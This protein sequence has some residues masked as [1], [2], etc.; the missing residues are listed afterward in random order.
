[1]LRKLEKYDILEEIGHGG[2]A[3]VY[4][5]RDQRL[6]REVAVKVLHPHLRGADEARSRFEREARSVARL[7]H[8]N[9]LEIYDYS[10]A[11]SEES[12]IA[13]ELL[14][15]PTLKHFAEAHPDMPAEIAAC[16][17]IQIARALAAA[18]ARGIIHRDVKPENVLL[19]ENRCIKLTD[20]G[21]AQIVDAQSFTATGQ[22]LGSPGHMAP[23]QVEGRD[24]DARTDLFSLG[25]VLYYLAA[26]RLPFRGNNPHQI[27]KRIVDGEYPDPLRVRPAV[28]SELGR[29]IERCLARDPEARYQSADE[30]AEDLCSFVARAGIEDP[31]AELQAYLAD[32]DGH[33]ALL[34]P[35]L[36]ARLADRGEQAARA[37]DYRGA[38]ECFD[39]AL[40]LDE[41]NARVLAQVERL[42][43]RSGRR[44]RVALLSGVALGMVGIIGMAV[45][46]AGRSQHA[47]SPE[48]GG[49]EGAGAADLAAPDPDVDGVEA[50]A[51]QLEDD[52]P[53]SAGEGLE[54][55]TGSEEASE[56]QD[57][58]SQDTVAADRARAVTHS[59]NRA[60]RL[61][62][63]PP[64]TVVL[65]PTP[66]NVL[67]G[68]DG[69]EP[70]P[71][72]PSFHRM[73]LEPGRH[74]FVFKSGSECCRDAEFTRV[75]PPGPGT[76]VVAERLPLRPAGL[77]VV[78]NVPGDVEVGDGLASG[79]TREVVRVPMRDDVEDVVRI[80]VT[81]PGYRVYTGAVRLQAGRVAEA[82]VQ[83]EA[84]EG[85]SR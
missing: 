24:C 74:R 10:G 30:L 4:R 51:D 76:T 80:T 62:D 81:S 2:M 3:T 50:P 34:V 49:D 61:R 21:I 72:G 14:T 29:I 5:A 79:R 18:H 26:G 15:G 63:G 11:G 85:A 67:V 8:P 23:E 55:D 75:I 70:R 43:R 37:G 83:L 32:P 35:R 84:A 57:E 17:G 82:G 58:P 38:L 44:R 73:E 64:R 39:R 25:T 54:D 31:Q 7:R 66:Q 45:A 6:D 33:T 48:E 40:A 71:F 36:V 69:E 27:L 42:R 28:G 22:V 13:A 78:S 9:I 52:T 59:K 20:F 12:Y 46:L 56:E 68:I 1:M 19:H 60:R 77:Y 65:R 53:E 16:F 47:P 41:G